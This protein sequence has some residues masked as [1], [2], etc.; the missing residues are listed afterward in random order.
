MTYPEETVV[1]TLPHVAPVSVPVAAPVIEGDAPE[2]R[3]TVQVQETSIK[4][5]IAVITDRAAALQVTNQQEYEAALEDA[6]VIKKQ[7]KVVTDFMAPI[8][9]ATD[10]AHKAACQRE[11]EM[12]EPLKKADAAIRACVNGYLTEQARLAR[13][14]EER[15]RRQKEEEERRLMEQAI[16][17]EQQGDTVAA[18]ETFEAAAIMADT[19]PIIP[20]AS[21][22]A[23]KGVSVKTDWEV[24]IINEDAVPVNIMGACV[25][26]VN[27]AAVK[28]LV[29][30]TGGKIKIPGIAIR[31]V[32]KTAVRG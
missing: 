14:A 7:M 4:Q 23:V 9:K 24:T 2:E 15:A 31:E 26:P 11:A 18:E 29:K 20:T 1:A 10:E 16:D 25:R 27:L 32:K 28:K 6:K 8:K 22:Q 19:A 13:E 21:V 5:E 30:A 3:S 17:A 12:L